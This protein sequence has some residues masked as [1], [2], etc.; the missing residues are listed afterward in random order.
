M[1]DLPIALDAMGGDHAP[2]VTIAGAVAAARL[3]VSVIL[4]GNQSCIEAELANY[5]TV[6]LAIQI[7]HAADYIRME[8]AASDVRRRP[9]VSINV[10]TTLVKQGRAAAVVSMGHSGATM[11]SALF[12]LGRLLGVDRPAIV[13]LMPTPKGRSIMLDIGANADVKAQYLVQWAVLA[14]RYLH[15]VDGIEKPS[16][17]L[18]SIGEEEGKG[19]ALVLEA[20]QMLKTNAEVHFFG[21]IEGRDIFAGTTDII[22]TDGFTGNVVLKTA[23]GEAKV[24]L[25][26]MKTALLAELPA[27]TRPQIQAALGQVIRRMDPNE[28]GASLLIGVQGL[29]FIGHGSGT[30]LAVERALCYAQQCA[31]SGLMD[32]LR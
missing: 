17:G 23:E 16:V 24:L 13:G 21:N 2:Q 29:S 30:A 10:A 28:Y 14:S 11:A 27:E 18:L 12:V 5:D 9:E 25:S 19:N 8:D 3:G 31:Q 22:L 6:G 1:P 32:R 15:I 7:E 26:W 4:V 20:Y